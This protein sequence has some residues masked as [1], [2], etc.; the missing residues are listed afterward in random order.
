VI[1]LTIGAYNHRSGGI[2]AGSD[3][4]LLRQL[5]MIQVLGLDALFSAEATGWFDHDRR[6]L[7]L[8]APPGHAAAPGVRPR[9][10]CNLVIFIRTDRLQVMEERHE[11]GHPWWHHTRASWSRWTASTSCCGW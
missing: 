2:D 7:H 1:R 5:D 8:A 4:R 11:Q 3:R 10:D 6:S 9:H